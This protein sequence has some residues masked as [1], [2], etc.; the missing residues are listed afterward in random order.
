[1][2]V[3]YQW[4]KELVDLEGISYEQLVKDLSLYIV[5]V[6][7]IDKLA[8]GTSIIT[9]K[10]LECVPHPDSDHL[11]VTKV[12][13]G[14]EILQVVCGAPNVE[15][16]QTV[17]L[18]LPG[19]KLPGG[20]IKPSLI[21]GVESNGMICSL[22]EVELDNK[23]IPEAYKNGIYVLPDDTPLGV[24]ALDY[25]GLNDDI[26]EL[27]L[28]PNRMDLLSMNGV[29]NDLAAFYHRNR[30]YEF[31]EVEESKKL[32]KEE[33]SVE[34][35]TKR[36][37]SYNARVIKNVK[38]AESPTFIKSR[39]MACG[40][41]PINNVVDIT[42]YILMLFGQPLHAFDQDI[43]GG[44][45]VVR[46]AYENEEV[47]T[48]DDVKRTL[49]P[50]DIVITDGKEVTCLGGVMGCSNT[51]VTDNTKNIVLEAAIFDPLS[52]RKTSSRL[53][54]RSES[55]TRFERGVDLNQTVEA[56]NYATFLLEK[57]AGGQA[58]AGV[59]SSGIDHIDDKVIKLALNDVTAY[60]GI[61]VAKDK[62]ED[63][64]NSLGF[65]VQLLEKDEYEITVPNRRMDITIKADLIEEIARMYGYQ[66]LNSTLPKQSQLG[67]LSLAQKRLK[68]IRH[69]MASLGLNEVNTYALVSDADN[70]LF[71]VLKPKNAKPIALL[72]PMSEDHAKLR[73]SIMP[74]LLKVAQYN[75]ARK[76]NDLALFELGSRYY[77]DGTENNID[78]SKEEIVL[79]G[80]LSGK[81]DNLS[82]GE[83]K[84]VDFF[85]VKGLLENLEHHLGISFKYQKM[86]NVENTMHPG[87]SAVIKFQNEVIGYLAALHPAYA[88]TLDLEDTYIFE[89]VL[90]KVL[91]QKASIIKFSPMV[92]KPVVV[93][94]FAFVMEKDIP[95]GDVVEAIYR[96]DRN[97]I[98]NVEVFDIYES[99]LLGSKRSVAFKVSLS[100]DDNLTDEVITEKT[101]KITDM[102]EQ[103]FKALLRM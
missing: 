77:I 61:E 93:R 82:W 9:A 29:A 49:N 44:K 21:R 64:L 80:L 101:K 63:I 27:G 85:T 33:L 55:S 84:Q 10:V 54:L 47:V 76:L 17:M 32:A 52:V 3:S 14:S 30:F 20:T 59:V 48:L 102:M 73:M 60:L 65:G 19:A 96:I 35:A 78:V 46:D 66:N 88:K 4:L 69:T 97:L 67:E 34:V 57:Y 22:Q 12:D 58:L 89:I 43:L 25:L 92:K 28:T 50:Q 81:F 74:S 98:S 71:N 11:H 95:V 26:I 68:T 90:T 18:A 83:K 70:N 38:I 99:A 94:D 79:A 36:C 6:D 62:F 15:A 5:E 86:D 2:K 8:K 1:M 24:D 31:G 51:E 13:T 72:H 39:L 40:I 37:L 45:I 100:S 103:K 87:R 7:A 53:G 23:Y 41:R 75:S 56:L 91:K 16:G 42:N